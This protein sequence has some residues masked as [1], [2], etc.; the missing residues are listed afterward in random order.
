[1]AKAIVSAGKAGIALAVSDPCFELWLIPHFADHNAH[2]ADYRAA[3]VLLAKHLPA[4]DKKLDYTALH[5]GLDAAIARAKALGPDNPATAMWRLVE[6]A[7][8]R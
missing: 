3:R 4:Y 8:N 1:M 2:I 5:Q 7:L 6:A